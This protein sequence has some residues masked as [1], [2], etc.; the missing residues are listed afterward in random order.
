[1]A[2]QLQNCRRYW[3]GYDSGEGTDDGVSLY[4]SGVRHGQLNGILRVTAGHFAE[5]ILRAKIFDAL[6]WIWWVG[7]DSYSGLAEDLLAAGGV[8]VGRIPVMAAPVDELA[9]VDVPA[10][11]TI[12]RVT[13]PG[14][15]EAWVNAYADPLGVA[16]DQRSAAVLMEAGHPE[17]PQHL[18]RFAGRMDGRI[19]A[20]S[21][22]LDSDGVAGIYVVATEESYRGRGIGAALTA[23]A[24]AEGRRRGLPVT[25]L[26]A[27]AMGR[28]VYERLGLRAVAEYRLFRYS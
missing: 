25:T 3:L 23:A 12:E 17:A 11:L 13:T 10:G 19:V 9:E 18:I 8:E 27:T 2:S 1:M 28:P 6:P 14:S 24:V 20:T 7:P 21:A 22:L 4:R 5:A 26:Q 16:T 15:L